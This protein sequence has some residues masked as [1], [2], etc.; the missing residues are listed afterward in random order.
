MTEGVYRGDSIRGERVLCTCRKS[1]KKQLYRKTDAHRGTRVVLEK[2]VTCI[3]E[4]EN[5]VL[6][7]NKADEGEKQ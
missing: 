5:R 4:K 6:T 7:R 3:I 1:L 2:D